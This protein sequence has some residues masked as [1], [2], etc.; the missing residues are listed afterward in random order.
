MLIL[1]KFYRLLNSSI[2]GVVHRVTGD[3]SEKGIGAFCINWAFEKCGNLR[4]DTHGDNIVMQNLL[5]KLRFNHCYRVLHKLL[6]SANITTFFRDCLILL[7][8]DFFRTF[9]CSCAR[10]LRSLNAITFT[11]WSFVCQNLWDRKF[12]LPL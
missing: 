4:I 12:F 3:G 6:K 7:R 5:K 11:F 2:A 10:S 9:L 1:C 8:A